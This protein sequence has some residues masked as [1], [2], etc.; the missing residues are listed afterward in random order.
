[1]PPSCSADDIRQMLASGDVMVH[2]DARLPGVVVPEYLAGQ[3]DLGL[4]LSHR[5]RHPIFLEDDAIYAALVFSGVPSECVIP[6]EAIWGAHDVASGK[7]PL[8]MNRVPAEIAGAL[9]AAPD[10]PA[11]ES[12]NRNG[13]PKH[14]HLALIQGNGNGNGRSKHPPLRLVK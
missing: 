6:Y 1:M 13:Q 9:T 11:G 7:G 14:P 8:W 4:V 2:L 5:F 10:V 3:P 12:A